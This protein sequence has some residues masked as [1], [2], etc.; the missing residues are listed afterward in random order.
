MKVI[1]SLLLLAPCLSALIISCCKYFLINVKLRLSGLFICFFI[2]LFPLFIKRKGYTRNCKKDAHALCLCYKEIY[3]QCT[4]KY[5]YYTR[6]IEKNRKMEITCLLCLWLTAYRTLC[7]T[8]APAGKP[9][10]QE[11]RTPEHG[12]RSGRN[13]DAK[14]RSGV[15][16]PECGSA[17][18]VR[19]PAGTERLSAMP[20]ERSE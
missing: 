18:W 8:P 2:P 16:A 14:R 19:C 17:E 3:A 9:P 4:R 15:R 7:H 11:D 13:G 12:V 10:A 6:G 20:T 5:F 1:C